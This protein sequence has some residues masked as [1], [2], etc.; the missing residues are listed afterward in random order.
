MNSGTTVRVW[1][2]PTRVFHWLLVI[3]IG[4]GYVSYRF[5]EAVGDNTMQWHRYNGYAVLVLIVWRLLWGVAGSSTSRF[6]TFVP[7]PWKAARYGL[8][9]VRG[10][11]RHFLGHNPLGTYMVLALLAAVGLQAILGLFS[12]EHNFLTW[13]P[14]THLISEDMT[15]KITHWHHTFF[16]RGLLVLIGLHIVANVL[17][18]LVKREPLIKAMVTGRK[19][20]TDYEDAAEAELVATPI[21]RAL[22]CLAVAAAIVLGGILALGGKLF[23]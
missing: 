6:S 15:K 16:W 10:R 19:P 5:S 11:D 9:L 13:G 17:Y 4:C 12:S 1:D 18:G 3:L 21:R 23:Y 14:L 7:W 20:A 2:I 8:D 22:G